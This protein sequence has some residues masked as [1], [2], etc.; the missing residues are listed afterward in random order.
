MS[1]Q[2]TPKFRPKLAT[3]AD[4]Y[5]LGK[6][7]TSIFWKN[8]AFWPADFRP[9]MAGKLKQIFFLESRQTYLSEKYILLGANV[10]PH[11]SKSILKNKQNST[12][13]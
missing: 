10:E 2:A 4:F 9:D 7:K 12:R 5:Q 3:P 11:G 6:S 1:K 8:E 13:L